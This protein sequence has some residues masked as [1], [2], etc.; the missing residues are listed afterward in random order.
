MR[1]LL[2]TNIIIDF[3]LEREPFFADAN[4]IFEAIATGQVEGYLSASSVTDIFYICRRLTQNR[5][6]AKTIVRQTLA[7]LNVCSIDRSVLEQA[8]DSG[9]SDFEDA[10]QIAAAIAANLDAIVTRNARDFQTNQIA[11]V[12][13][14]QLLEQLTG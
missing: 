14:S 1:V 10:V 12:S 3:F 13:V 5:E 8:I 6:E 11:V 9:I 4:A 7:V 2:D